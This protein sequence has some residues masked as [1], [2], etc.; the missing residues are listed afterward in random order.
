MVVGATCAM[1]PARLRR[2]EKGGKVCIRV[3]PTVGSAA[4]GRAISTPTRGK[5]G[6][7]QWC[8]TLARALFELVWLWMVESLGGTTHKNAINVA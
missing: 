4:H 7:Q 3:L 2:R 1:M 5:E 6:R 8:A